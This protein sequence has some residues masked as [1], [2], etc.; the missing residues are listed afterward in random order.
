MPDPDPL[1]PLRLQI[2]QIDQQLIELLNSRARIVVQIGKLKQSQ[3][4]PIYAPDREKAILD[5]VRSLNRGPLSDR[6]LEAVYREVMSGSFALEKPLRIGFLGP[7]GSFSH[8]AAISKFGSSVDYVPLADI[9]GVFEAVIRGHADYGLAPIENSLHGGVID[10]LD[11]FL[12]HSARIC[13]E[14][15]TT[16]HHNLL[17]NE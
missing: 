7:P 16:I 1:D 15:L 17:A 8:A 11:A 3:G 10:T 6:C 9:P 12:H 14:V 5:R 13:A 4:T 2:D